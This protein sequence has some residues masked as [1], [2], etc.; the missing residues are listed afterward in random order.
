M[1]RILVV[2]DETALTGFLSELLESRGYNV[3][4]VNNGYDALSVFK[5]DPTAIDLV[6]TD[7]TMPGITGAEM[8]TEILA[9]R[10]ELP[11]ILTTGYSELVDEASAKA[12]GIRAYLSKP[13][14]TQQ[15]LR[16]IKELLLYPH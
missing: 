8:A 9:L 6:F 2:D 12:L 14:E 4:V 10:P 15:I 13:I 1:G 16:T 7:Q 11:I 5:Q 3:I